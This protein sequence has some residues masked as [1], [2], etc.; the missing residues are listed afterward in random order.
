MLCI[1]SLDE[2]VNG[3]IAA[4]IED[5]C[6]PGHGDTPAFGHSCFFRCNR[7]AY[8]EFGIA[9]GDIAGMGSDL[10]GSFAEASCV[11]LV[12]GAHPPSSW[13]TPR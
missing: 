8:T 3:I 6:E 12:V 9:I 7:K 13:P 4:A 11:A 5:Y 2:D 1:C 10:F